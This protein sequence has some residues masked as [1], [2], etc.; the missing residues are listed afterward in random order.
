MEQL[1]VLSRGK[2][3]HP[4]YTLEGDFDTKGSEPLLVKGKFVSRKGTIE[5]EFDVKKGRSQLVNG[6]VLSK[7]GTLVKT[8]GGGDGSVD[9]QMNKKKIED[10]LPLALYD[11]DGDG[12]LSLEELVQCLR[13]YLR[14]LYKTETKANL[15][16]S[17]QQL[18]KAGNFTQFY[19]PQLIQTSERSQVLDRT[20]ARRS[21]GNR[22]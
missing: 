6:K 19:Q 3:V 2:L 7:D 5:G 17:V 4:Q 13:S 11:A 9:P 1:V 12:Y 18:F 14:F 16:K 21:Q 22:F 10:V 20:R 15:C 8:V